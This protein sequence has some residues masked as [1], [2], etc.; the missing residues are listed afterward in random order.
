MVNGML[1][2][3]YFENHLTFIEDMVEPLT[4]T[5]SIGKYNVWANVH[6]GGLSGGLERNFLAY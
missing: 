1:A 4:R 3:E 6:G 5:G 2:S